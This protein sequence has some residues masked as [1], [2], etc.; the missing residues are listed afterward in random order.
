MKIDI[1]DIDQALIDGAIASGGTIVSTVDGTGRDGTPACATV[2]LL[3]ARVQLHATATEHDAIPSQTSTTAC[4][5]P[6]LLAMASGTP[7]SLAVSSVGTPR[8]S[9][10]AAASLVFAERAHLG[11]LSPLFP[12]SPPPL[13]FLLPSAPP[14]AIS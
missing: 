9:D 4:E 12:L 6:S 1:H 5:P 10:V 7:S 13:P 2:P 14:L 3:P 11:R 8:A